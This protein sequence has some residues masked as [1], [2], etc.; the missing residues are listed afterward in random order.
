MIPNK[1]PASE[2]R[3]RTLDR[4]DLNE[5]GKIYI[6]KGGTTTVDGV[7]GVSDITAKNIIDAINE[8]QT[9]EKC[10]Q[11]KDENNLKTYLLAYIYPIGSI[12][13]TAENTN[14]STYLG[15]TWVAWGAG[16]VPVGVD[17]S[18]TDFATVEQTGGEKTHKLTVDE[19]AVH[20]HSG[21]SSSISTKGY[22]KPNDTSGTFVDFAGTIT[23]TV[24]IETVDET[25]FKSYYIDGKIPGGVTTTVTQDYAVKAGGGASHNN[26]QPY[27]TCYMW[28]R[29]A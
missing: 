21:T 14:P 24:K 26:L 16:K 17:D 15:G 28:K 12:K 5:K 22:T 19:L 13:M 11:L 3:V 4:N 25:S 1:R 20:E 2:Y 27:I 8:N 9:N 7:A 18:D 23:H 10:V 29:T 6:G